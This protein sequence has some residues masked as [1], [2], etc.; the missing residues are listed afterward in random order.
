M[1][2]LV[3]PTDRDFYGTERTC[4]VALDLNLETEDSISISRRVCCPFEVAGNE[5]RYVSASS[6]V[7]ANPQQRGLHKIINFLIDGRYLLLAP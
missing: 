4:Q 6:E 2:L 5:E 3:L 7:K 1:V